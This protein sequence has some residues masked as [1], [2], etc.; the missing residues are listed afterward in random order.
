MMTMSVPVTLPMIG[1]VPLPE[2]WQ[3]LRSGAR[4][5]P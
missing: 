3:R 1:K 5:R 2:L 4:Q